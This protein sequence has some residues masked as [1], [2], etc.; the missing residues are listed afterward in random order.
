MNS[1][2]DVGRGVY[3]PKAFV[4][5]SWDDDA[6]NK[7]VAELAT[8]LR[9]DGIDIT[10]DQWN[11]VSGDQLTSFMEKEIRENDSVLNRTGFVGGSNS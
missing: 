8:K 3:I 5:Y 10:L 7:W 1:E 4:S 11:T 9:A 2:N 6:H